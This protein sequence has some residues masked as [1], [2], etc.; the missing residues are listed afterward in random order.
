MAVLVLEPL[1]VHGRP[2]CGA[3]HQET[4]RPRVSRLPDQVPHS[5][6]PEHRI[7]EVDRQHWH[8][9]RR[10]RGPGRLEA[11]HRTSLRDALFQ[12]LACAILGV[13]E[14]QAGI[15]GLV[16]LTLRGVDLHLREERVEPERAS[17]VGHDG[18]DVLADA[19]VPEQV[20]Q[21]PRER[22]GRRDGL[23]ARAEREL[24]KSCRLRRGKPEKSATADDPVRQVPAE[25]TAASRQV[26]VH[27][28]SC[29]WAIVRRR[30][31]VERFVGDL[32]VQVQPVA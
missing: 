9:P 28:R 21:Q 6:E 19:G 4:T 26:L 7:E 25:R 1:A 12:D 27:R 29:R 18:D 17:F 5:L 8:G 3:A 20:A 22:H 23:A 11:R 10:V 32:L 31:R 2:P 30:L 16:E 24:G 14:K 13:R 15:D